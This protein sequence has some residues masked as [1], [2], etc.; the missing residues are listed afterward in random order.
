[1]AIS[2][3]KLYSECEVYG[4]VHKVVSINPPYV[5]LKRPDGES[6]QF[7]YLSLITDPSFKP[8]KSMISRR[9]ET[10]TYENE[11]AKLSER[12]REE[13]GRR[14]EVIRPLVLLEKI[15]EG[16]IQSILL[17]KDKYQ[18][19]IEEGEEV[20][21]IRQKDIIPRIIK[22]Y[23]G[24]RATIL[25][26]FKSY[27]AA[28]LD[29]GNGLEGLISDKGKGYT[30]R[31]DNKLMTICHPNN[32]ELILDTLILRLPDNQICILKEAIEKNYL[33]KLR[34]SKAEIHRIIEQ[35]CRLHEIPEIP[36]IT[37]AGIIGR[38]DEK[39]LVLMRN[40]KKAKQIYD[41]VARG[42]ADREA[43]GR[44]DII[45][46]DHTQIDIP[47]IDDVTG[48]IIERPWFTLGICVH[49][50]SPWCMELSH[51]GPSTNIVRKAILH[52]VLVKNTVRDYGTETEWAAFGIPNLIYVDNGMDFK[53]NDIKRLVNETLQSEI[54]H[55][56]VKLP[57]YGAVIERLFGTINRELI[58]NIMGTTKSNIFERGE[59][60]PENEAFLTLSQLRKILILYLTDI[61]PFKPHRGLGNNQTPRLKYNESLQEMGYPHT[62]FEDEV[63]RYKI[64]FLITDKK[65]YTRDGVRWENRIY[66]SGKC[67]DIIGT[68][69]KKYTV[70]Y[71]YDDISMIYLLHPHTKEFVEL[72]CETPPYEMVSGVNRFTYQ[73]MEE[74]LRNDGEIKSKELMGKNQIEK[75]W[76]KIREEISKGY[77]NKKSIRQMVAKMGEVK[78]EIVTPYMEQQALQ[79]EKASKA[80]NIEEEL[81]F[82]AKRAEETR[83]R[84]A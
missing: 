77:M 29:T 71:N 41:D 76:K 19:L 52:G 33:T 21:K 55:R 48:M 59:L 84:E 78:I 63:E 6:V 16:D 65:P 47:V 37:V 54:R 4:K 72:H 12:K 53:S 20:S 7:D 46:I 49:S 3:L 50:R 70:K 11:L 67:V 43:F 44:L 15:N 5:W 61:Y 80:R 27:R 25:R 74:M 40:Y 56:P 60:D 73:K 2:Q 82:Q 9:N 36:Y 62:I 68:R 81:L 30:G 8:H 34:L 24:S 38:I 51:E 75:A 83:N 32:P 39:A 64:D 17:F 42:Y 28:E 22:H 58:H 13:V 69:K 79:K 66:K 14:F 31:K 57:H 18:N 45:Q 10:R 26:Y 23:G 35:K 1:M